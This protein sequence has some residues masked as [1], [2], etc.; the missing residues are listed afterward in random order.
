VSYR[1]GEGRRVALG[2]VGAMPAPNSERC[3]KNFQ[4]DQGFDA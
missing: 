3:T 2:P 4:G 1:I